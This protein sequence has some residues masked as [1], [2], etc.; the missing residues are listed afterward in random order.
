MPIKNPIN[1]MLNGR[2]FFPNNLMILN[3]IISAPPVSDKISPR[4]APKKIIKPIHFKVFPNPFNKLSVT[5]VTVPPVARPKINPN[6]SKAGMACTL[7]TVIAT[8]KSAMQSSKIRK[9]DMAEA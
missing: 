5:E 9:T 2:N 1:D 6:K 7:K 4:N 8:I 3:A